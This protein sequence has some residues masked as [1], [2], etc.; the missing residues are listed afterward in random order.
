[1]LHV[2]L[3]ADAC[4]RQRHA[5][6]VAARNMHDP[7]DAFVAF[8]NVAGSAAG[9]LAGRTF[10]AKDLLDVAGHVTGGGNP[11]WPRGRAPAA[12]HAAAVQRLLDAGASLV[13]KTRTDEL[14][15]GI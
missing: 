8:V 1:M 15:R 13:G 7:Y 10:A 14:S 3:R 2:A 12:Q 9:P 6:C 11:D 5:C 4:I